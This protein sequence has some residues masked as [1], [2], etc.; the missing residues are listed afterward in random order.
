MCSGNV[1][2]LRWSTECPVYTLLSSFIQQT[3]VTYLVPTMELGYPWGT[4]QLIHGQRWKGLSN[5]PC[6]KE[7]EGPHMVP[8]T[9]YP[10]AYLKFGSRAHLK[11][12]I[13]LTKVWNFRTYKKI[14]KIVVLLAPSLS[15]LAARL[16]CLSFKGD[17]S[18]I[19]H[20]CCP[21]LGLRSPLLSP[22]REF[23]SD[24]DFFS[25]WTCPVTTDFNG[26]NARPKLETQE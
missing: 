4:H 18:S 17:L 16:S 13:P 12:H 23:G 11:F 22:L 1:P 25:F 3:S 26:I 24:T 20:I 6:P 9:Y 8:L 14:V 10:L 2:W 21:F 19:C 7:R 15:S 5:C